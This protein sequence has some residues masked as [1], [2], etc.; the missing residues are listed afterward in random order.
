MNLVA[1]VK[2]A[3]DNSRRQAQVQATKAKVVDA[4]RSLFVEGGY[5]GTS[6]EAIAAA[7]HTP[8]ATV[9]RLFGSKIGILTAVL[10]VAFVGDDEPVALHDRPMVKAAA[11]RQD[12]RELLAGFARV[13][14]QVLGRSGRLHQVLRAA[15]AVDPDA[16][17]LLAEVNRQRLDG[18]SRVAR[19]LAD[20]GALAD[21]LTVR[22]ATDVIYTL[23]SPDVHRLLTEER[24]WSA[25]RYERWLAGALCAVLLHADG[26][27]AHRRDVTY[28]AR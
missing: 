27:G 9:Y 26:D 18:Q 24:R 8:V 2:R 11:A 1:A 7:A 6:I 12:A 25:E 14:R 28:P 22:A 23:M 3:Y 21:G 15:A 17:A 10:D 4:A 16:A 20:R 19:M 13:S 5:V